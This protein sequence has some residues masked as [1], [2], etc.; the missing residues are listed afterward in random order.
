MIWWLTHA[1]Y[2]LS[3]RDY[4]RDDGWQREPVSTVL[5]KNV[6]DDITE[7]DVCTNTASASNYIPVYLMY[8]Q[9]KHGANISKYIFTF[10]SA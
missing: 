2:F 8:L 9:Y 5:I 4:R 6:P 3:I 10:V 1:C 7:R